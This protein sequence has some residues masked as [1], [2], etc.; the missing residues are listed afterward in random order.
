[1][2]NKEKWQAAFKVKWFELM[3]ADSEQKIDI[4]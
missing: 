3:Q 4:M 2:K 1:M